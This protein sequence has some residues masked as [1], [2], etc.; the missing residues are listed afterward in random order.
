MKETN[1]I[2]ASSPFRDRGHLVKTLPQSSFHN[3]DRKTWQR[4]QKIKLSFKHKAGPQL[5]PSPF[6]TELCFCHQLY[7]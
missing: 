5:R 1:R 4:L 7:Q 3:E 2:G 6:Y